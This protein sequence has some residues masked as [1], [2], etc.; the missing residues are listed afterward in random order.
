MK[1]GRKEKGRSQGFSS[2][3]FESAPESMSSLKQIDAGYVCVA[4]LKYL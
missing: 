3:R 4:I 1:K 2:L